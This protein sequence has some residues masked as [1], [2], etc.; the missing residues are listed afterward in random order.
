MENDLI[1]DCRMIRKKFSY[2]SLNFRFL[3]TTVYLILKV[4]SSV[5]W[6]VFIL[7]MF[8]EIRRIILIIGLKTL[9]LRIII[10]YAIQ[11]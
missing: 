3:V 4:M 6:V 2:L 7:I 1:V 8:F 11:D 9:E 10:T 5:F